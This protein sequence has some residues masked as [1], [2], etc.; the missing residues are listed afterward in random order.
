MV[1]PSV[2]LVPPESGYCLTV[3]TVKDGEPGGESGRGS[4]MPGASAFWTA[5]LVGLCRA[6]PRA[7][8]F[9]LGPAHNRLTRTR[10]ACTLQLDKE[11]TMRFLNNTPEEREQLERL[12]EVAGKADFRRHQKHLKRARELPR[13]AAD[14]ER[15]NE[16]DEI[17]PIVDTSR[18]GT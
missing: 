12:L 6:Q 2:A 18:E 9:I 15:F 17:G 14:R 5:G 8:R 1:S 4:L 10:N 13:D 3:S 11:V 7:M 16:S